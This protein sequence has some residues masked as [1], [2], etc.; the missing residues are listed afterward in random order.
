[1]GQ[2]GERRP[3]AVVRGLVGKAAE[4]GEKAADLPA[5][6]VEDAGRAPALRAAHD[7]IVTV[8]APHP[9]KLVGDEIKRAL[10]RHRHEGLASAAGAAAGTVRE[11]TLPHHR[12]RN[13]ARRM[14]RRRHRFEQG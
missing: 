6:I 3:E 5:R 8:S 4:G 11:V 14:H 2:E 7:G 9:V 10:P 13:A 12:L 1:M